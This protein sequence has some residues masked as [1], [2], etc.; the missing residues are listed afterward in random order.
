MTETVLEERR[1]LDP[2]PEPPRPRRRRGRGVPFWLMAPGFSVMSVV[3]YLPLVLAIIISLTTLNAFTIGDFTTA[4]WAG[5]RNYLD[6]LDPAGP[7][8]VLGSLRTSVVFSLLTT[9]VSLPLGLGA[10]MLVNQRFRGRGVLRTVFLLPF[11]LPAFAS[12]LIWRL[13]FQTETGAVDQFLRAAGLGSGDT[14]W[15]I[16]PNSFWVLAVTGIWTSW[17][18]VYIMLLAALQSIP[19][20]YYEAAAV[21]GA[22]PVRRFWSITLPAIKPTLALA[23][24]LSVINHFNNFTLPFILFGSPPPPQVNVLPVDIYT[25][26]FTAF[27]F[28]HAAAI[29]IV[30]LVVL[31]VPVAYYLRRVNRD[32]D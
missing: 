1:P 16:G 3:T 32:D 26:S 13:M 28:G 24:C 8:S 2:K 7:L 25:A 4:H 29:A 17:P 23:A 20:E 9:V 15:L 21:D 10:A 5:P 18:F 30:N 31:L 11:I 14:I 22:G 12:A 27:D 19:G 6:S